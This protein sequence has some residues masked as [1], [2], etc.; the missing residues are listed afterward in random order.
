VWAGNE[1]PKFG[2]VSTQRNEYIDSDGLNWVDSS[3]NQNNYRVGEQ[4]MFY[5]HLV[6][7]TLA[8]IIEYLN[9]EAVDGKSPKAEAIGELV[10]KAM[11][12]NV[13]QMYIDY[14]PDYSE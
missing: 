12:H 14:V 11:R 4:S 6:E 2:N 9:Y 7:R 10:K 13:I 3:N 8:E 5:F 1:Q